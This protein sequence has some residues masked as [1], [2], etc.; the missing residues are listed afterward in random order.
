M[1]SGITTVA[2]REATNALLLASDDD[3]DEE[4]LI[5]PQIAAKHPE[6]KLERSVV[7]SDFYSYWVFLEPLAALDDESQE[8]DDDVSAPLAV[9]RSYGEEITVLQGLDL[10][11]CSRWSAQTGMP[12]N[13]DALFVL[14]FVEDV[15][16]SNR[17]M[18]YFGS[19]LQRGTPWLC[20]YDTLLQILQTFGVATQLS[21]LCEEYNKQSTAGNSFEEPQV[22]PRLYLCNDAARHMEHVL[23]SVRT[24]YEMALD[25]YVPM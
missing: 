3:S 5:P 2:E 17:A 18:Q 1:K 10:D 20:S 14:C 6:F 15:E 4:E 23:I 22:R 21:T 19:L 16:T 8:T 7:E 13:M 24:S 12:I 25:R 11:L 9:F